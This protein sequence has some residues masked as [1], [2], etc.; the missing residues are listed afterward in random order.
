[1]C[2]DSGFDLPS[3]VLPSPTL[4]LVPP[5]GEWRKCAVMAKVDKGGLLARGRQGLHLMGGIGCFSSV[6]RHNIPEL[7]REVGTF[8]LFC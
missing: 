8:E 5:K 3:G 1:M 2:L 4:R 6:N 7:R